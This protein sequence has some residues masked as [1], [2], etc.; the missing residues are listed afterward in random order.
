MLAAL[1]GMFARRA[2]IGRLLAAEVD[3]RTAAPLLELNEK[4]AAGERD[5]AALAAAYEAL[6]ER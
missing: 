6:R 4:I 5:A 1:R 2:P 3:F